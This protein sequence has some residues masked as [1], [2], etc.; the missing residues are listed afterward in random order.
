MSP[1]FIYYHDNLPIFMLN[2]IIKIEILLYCFYVFIL[3]L[4]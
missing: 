4:F 2:F 1:L 3:K